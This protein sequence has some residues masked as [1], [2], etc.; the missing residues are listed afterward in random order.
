[1]TKKIPEGYHTVT[2][3]L[4]LKDSHKAIVFYQKAL[5]AQVMHVMP[6]LDGKGVMHAALKIGDSIIMMGDEMPQQKRYSA[7][8]IGDTPVAFYLYVENVDAAFKKAVDAGATVLMPP[9]DMFWGDRVGAL[10]DPFGY[11]W[12]FATH[13]KD[14]SPEEMQREAVAC[15]S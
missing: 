8:T 9:N 2:P 3:A 7:E 10:I 15:Q 12:T 14:L 4:I 1:M 5:G 6:G 13:I 11:R